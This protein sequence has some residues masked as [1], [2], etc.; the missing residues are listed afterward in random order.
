MPFSFSSQ[1]STSKMSDLDILGMYRCVPEHKPYQITLSYFRS[2]P[3]FC[4]YFGLI[5]FQDSHISMRIFLVKHAVDLPSL[6]VTKFDILPYITE[7]NI[8]GEMS[9]KD[10]NFQ[11][12]Y[13]IS[14]RL[15]SVSTCLFPYQL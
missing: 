6:F 9:Q 5:E 13:S 11:F 12:D 14:D 15:N 1:N 2:V 7:T 3:V 8:I 4:K 10:S